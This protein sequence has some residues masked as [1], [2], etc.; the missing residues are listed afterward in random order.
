MVSSNTISEPSVATIKRLFAV[1]GNRCAFPKCSNQLVEPT[2]GKVTGRICHIKGRKPGGPRYDPQQTDAERH[3]FE[4]LILMCPI[5]HDVIDADEI[6]YTVERLQ[7]IKDKHERDNT[8]GYDLNNDA[9][10]KLIA[11]IENNVVVDG[12]IIFTQNQMGGQ[13]A[14]QITNV[15]PLPRRISVAAANALIVALSKLP[16]VEAGITIPMG[17]AESHQLAMVIEKVLTQAGWHI[18]TFGYAQFIDLPRGII[19]NM[20]TPLDAVNVF[21]KWLTSTG[22]SAHGVVNPKI[23]EIE[24]VVGTNL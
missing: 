5:H 6:A 16:P 23:T 22:L 14:H 8:N 12:S 15:G 10:R 13:V 3:A 1:S 9:A 17:D 2:T 18:K 20:P 11:S 24:I 4:N 7:A 21:G 19:I